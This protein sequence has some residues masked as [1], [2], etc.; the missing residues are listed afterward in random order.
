MSMR[1]G[2]VVRKFLD[3]LL[4]FTALQSLTFGV[5][6]RAAG[7]CTCSRSGEENAKTEKECK[8][9]AKMGKPNPRDSYD[10][11]APLKGW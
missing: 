11:L 8:C 7:Q 3:T 9:D 2:T 5:G 10:Y 6:K 4:Q 1:F